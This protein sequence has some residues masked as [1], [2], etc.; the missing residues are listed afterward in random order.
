[1]IRKHW[2]GFN[3]RWL[4]RDN[5]QEAKVETSKRYR[6]LLCLLVWS[7]RHAESDETTYMTA[8]PPGPRW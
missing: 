1:M 4:P 6:T 2:P 5:R 3:K 7:L 8:W